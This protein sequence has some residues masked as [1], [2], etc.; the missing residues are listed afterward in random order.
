M[1][2]SCPFVGAHYIVDLIA[3]ATL[4]WGAIRIA[5]LFGAPDN[6]HAELVWISK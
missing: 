5:Q 2:A 3:G 4:G 1:I 6:R